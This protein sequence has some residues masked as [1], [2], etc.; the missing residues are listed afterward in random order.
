MG[1]WDL[2]I[3]I[4]KKTANAFKNPTQQFPSFPYGLIAK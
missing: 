1:W 3:L 2:Y 4:S